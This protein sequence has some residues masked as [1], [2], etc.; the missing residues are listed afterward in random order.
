MPRLAAPAFV[1]ALQRGY[2][3]SPDRRVYRAQTTLY[4]DG[5]PDIFASVEPTP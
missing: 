2:N 5:V 1:A 4:A 3:S